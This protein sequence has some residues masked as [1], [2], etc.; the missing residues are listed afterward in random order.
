MLGG[1]IKAVF[2][3]A[4]GTLLAPDPSFH[5]IYGRVLGPLGVKA[6]PEDLRRAAMATWGEFDLAIGRGTD[7]YSHF[8]GGERE[9]WKRFVRRT[10]ERLGEAERAEAAAEALQSAFSDPKVWA[11]FPEVARTMR[12]LRERGLKLGVISNWDSRLRGILDAHALSPQFDTIVV[13]CEVGVEKPGAEIFAHA[14]RAVGLAP[15]EALHVGDDHV[16]D[17]EGSRAAGMM[18]VLLVRQ[19]APPHG[20]VAVETLEGLVGLVDGAR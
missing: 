6:G 15:G 1:T 5:E 8:P 12:S 17:Y 19:G 18:G 14:L 20:A 2:F 16:S 10:L 9:Y 11:V 13:S 3:D 4:G 7:R